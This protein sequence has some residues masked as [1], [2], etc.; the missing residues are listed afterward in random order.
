MQRKRGR[1]KGASYIGDVSYVPTTEHRIPIDIYAFPP[2]S[3]IIMQLLGP[4]GKHQQRMKSESDSIVTTS[5]K[6]S[7]GPLLPG[8]EPLT[9]VIRSKDPAIPLTQRQ[10]AIVH[11][12][13][14][15]ILRHVKEY[16]LGRSLC[17]LVSSPKKK[18]LAH[19]FS[20]VGV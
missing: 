13:Y 14:E 18:S 17:A 4:R 11:Q 15:D 6:G 8:E 19:C 20:I 7:R 10:V 16:D 12:I 2:D 1:G 9:L 5:G 3:N